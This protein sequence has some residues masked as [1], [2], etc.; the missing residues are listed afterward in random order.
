[1]SKEKIDIV[2]IDKMLKEDQRIRECKESYFTKEEF[3]AFLNNTNF[4]YV[5]KCYMELITGFRYIAKEDRINS[6]YKTIDIS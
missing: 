5:Q 2:K 3:M 6:L 1:M 4:K